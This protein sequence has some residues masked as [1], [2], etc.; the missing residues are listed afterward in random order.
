MLPALSTSSAFA[1][2]AFL[3][4]SIMIGNAWVYCG[5]LLIAA[6]ARGAEYHVSTSGNDGAP[7]SAGQPWRTIQRAVNAAVGGDTILVHGGIYSERVA[8]SGKAATAALPIVLA[9]APSEQA[10]VDQTGVNPPNDTSALLHIHNSNHIT[11]RGIEFRN[12]QTTSDTKTPVG[13]Y[14]TGACDGVRLEQNKVHGIWQSNTELDNFDANAHGIAAYGD[15]ATPI[16]NLVLDGNEVYDLRLGASEAV[17]L[18]G[19]VTNFQVVRN[20]VHDCNNLGID[21][22]G[23]E[24]VNGTVALDQARN[25]RCA[26]NLVYNIDTQFNPAYG[27][28][29]A[30]SFPDEDER[31]DTRAAAGIYV[32]GGANIVIERNHVHHCN[33]GLEV[34]SEHGGRNASGITVRNNLLRSNHVAGLFMGGADT[35]NGGITN[36]SFTHNT[37][38]QNDTAGHGGG[39]VGIQHHVSSTIIRHNIIVCNPATAQF[40]LYEATDGTFTANAIDWNLY[41]GASVNAVDFTWANQNRTTFATWKSLSS[42]DAHSLFVGSPGFVNAAAVDFNLQSSSAAVNAGDPTFAPASGELD[43]GGLDRLVNGRV[44]IGM[45]E[46]GVAGPSVQF[47]VSAYPTVAENAGPITVRLVR[48]GDASAA[49]DVTLTTGNMGDTAVAGTDYTPHPGTIVHF[50]AAQTEATIPVQLLDRPGVQGTRNFTVKLSSPTS[51]VTLGTRATATAS[52]KDAAGV[53]AINLPPASTIDVDENAGPALIPIARTSGMDGTVGFRITTTNGSATAGTDFTAPT[54]LQSM[55]NG[56]TTLNVPIPIINAV[57]TEPSETFTVTISAPTG[58]STLGAVASVTVRINDVDST[59]PSPPT[60]TTPATNGFKLSNVNSGNDYTVGGAATDNKAV[61]HVEIRLNGA[62]IGDAQLASPGTAST[63]WARVITP[64]TGLNTLTAQTFDTSGRFSTVTTRTFTTLRPLIVNGA[65]SYGKVTAG[66]SG[67]TYR[68]VGQSFT[69]TATPTAGGLFAGWILHGDDMANNGDDFTPQRLGAALSALEKPTLTFIFREGLILEAHFVA[70]PYTSTVTG[71]YNGLINASPTLPDRA[72]G[73]DGSVPGLGTE[74]YFSATVM[75]T[76]AFSGKLL[77]DGFVL[78]LA[79]AF[80]QQGRA[81]FGTARSFT[82][83][84]ARPNKPS[85]IVKLDIG[86]PALS[87]ALPGK[88]TGEVTAMQFPLGAGPASVSTVE[89]DRSHFTGLTTALTVPDDYLTVTGVAASPVGR[90]DG[91]FTICLPSV[92]LAS[93]P[94]RIAQVFTAEDYPQGDGVG[95]LRVTKAGL[96]TLTATLA[97][98]TPVTASSTL[99]SDLR[100]ALFA[101]LYSLKGFLSAPIQLDRTQT[102][103]DLKAQPGKPV[104]WSRPFISTSHYYPFGWAETL[105]VDLLGAK[106]GATSNQSM[107]KAPH[108]APLQTA[109]ADGNVTLAFSQGQLA[110]DLVKFANLSTS[111]VVTKVPGNDLTFTMSVNRTTGAITGTFSHTDDT[112]PAYNAIIFQKGP[113]AGAHGYFLTKQPVPIDYIGESGRVLILGQP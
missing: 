52:I 10:V 96:V 19:N 55:V 72:S 45:D 44:D 3:A 87:V 104:L 94:D 82:Q 38:Y 15:A 50:D 4:R 88:I 110:S 105:E 83:T 66:F 5:C 70:N 92:P 113:H 89:A 2:L 42:Q 58:G 76:G 63:Q 81:R 20:I 73:D 91:V 101:Q 103:S 78:N 1:R 86:G 61:D 67:P 23:F 74:G 18:N 43:F 9:S 79:G 21:F 77:I 26:E 111:D 75:G 102:D 56:V 16:N 25:G 109:D 34:A 7:G 51:G 100:T 108:G 62:L 36:C 48:S 84:V 24:G 41:S 31:N 65:S 17:V 35:G 71:T 6:T 8:I 33:F 57:S 112:K 11:I 64:T 32:D 46:F 12:Y 54:A 106:Y 27:G 47:D 97:D 49:F 59:A 69:V 29:F 60:I 93:Q 13:I 40:V 53:L 37:I 98:G 30:G 85:L 107:L 99:S 95:T 39:Q 80:D 28:N 14:I 90:T 22:I 68:E